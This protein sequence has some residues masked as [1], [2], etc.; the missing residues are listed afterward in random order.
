MALES[1]PVDGARQ[2]REQSRRS[3][4]LLAAEPERAVVR[5]AVRTIWRFVCD[6]RRDDECVAAT[7]RTRSGTWI[8]DAVVKGG[9]RWTQMK[10]RSDFKP[11]MNAHRKL[12]FF[13]SAFIS[14]SV[15]SIC[16]SSVFM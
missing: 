12:I 16:V 5:R 4:R 11:L 6:D 8:R 9:H 15:F 3:T 7:A 13:S 2:Q 1:A 14:G 10:H